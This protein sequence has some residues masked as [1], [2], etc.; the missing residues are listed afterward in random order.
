MGL[1]LRRG[2]FKIREVGAY[3]RRFTVLYFKETNW[4]IYIYYSYYS[5]LICR[6]LHARTDRLQVR[7]VS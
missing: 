2:L 3:Y 1:F 4:T 6:A 7:G 5:S